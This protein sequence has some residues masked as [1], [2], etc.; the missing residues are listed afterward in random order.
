MNGEDVRDVDAD[1]NDVYTGR[2]QVELV[3][4]PENRQI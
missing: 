2:G 3:I 1:V 4:V